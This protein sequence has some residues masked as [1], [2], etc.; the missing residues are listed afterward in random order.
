MRPAIFLLI[1]LLA[2]AASAAVKQ[3]TSRLR[4]GDSEVRINVYDNPEGRL[5]FFAPH[6]DEQPALQ[7]AKEF[8]AARGGRL[9]EIE[10]ID[11]SGRP[12]RYLNF[13]AGGRSYS[14]DPNRIYTANGRA[15]G[16]PAEIRPLVAEFAEQVLSVIFG[17]DREAF[18][19]AGLPLIAVHNNADADRSPQTRGRDLSATA[20]VNAG[21]YSF[22]AAGAF[23]SNAEDDPDNFIFLTTPEHIAYFS[24]FGFNIVV[25][26]PAASL[27]SGKCSVDDGSLSV[28]SSLSHI[29]Y[30][31]LEADASTGSIRQR[32]MLEAVYQLAPLPAVAK[33]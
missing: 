19:A 6:F 33:Q 23:I 18:R 2:S 28:Y 21:P 1:L 9:I 20:F 15:C 11:R 7:A 8:I 25:Q 24:G 14:I 4:L 27:A 12:S 26:R 29:P 13:T 31:C 32:Q 16:T 5:T 10:S 22:Q 30:I 17:P 3:S